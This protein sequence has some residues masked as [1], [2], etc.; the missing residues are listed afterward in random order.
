[1]TGD[2]FERDAF[3][4]PQLRLAMGL[5]KFHDL[6]RGNAC[7]DQSGGNRAIAPIGIPSLDRLGGERGEI[8]INQRDMWGRR[9][10]RGTGGG[11]GN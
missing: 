7:L 9:G 3:P 2:I 8:R 6:G 5:D 1:M 10:W 4:D 11:W